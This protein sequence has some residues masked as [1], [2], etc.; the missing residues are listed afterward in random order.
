MSEQKP[1]QAHELD[2]D[3]GLLADLREAF[4]M[5]FESSGSQEHSR[6][7]PDVDKLSVKGSSGGSGRLGLGNYQVGKAV[8]RFRGRRRTRSWGYGYGF[9][10][11]AAFPGTGGRS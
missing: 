8:G 1:Q 5:E 6:L 7:W 10:C 2:G 11:P 9:S 4:G 3:D